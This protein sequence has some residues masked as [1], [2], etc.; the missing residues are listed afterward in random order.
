MSICTRLA[1]GRWIPIPMDRAMTSLRKLVLA[2]AA[3]VREAV[4][5][6]RCSMEVL[7][8]MAMQKM[9]MI[10]A[11]DFID[12]SHRRHHSLTTR[13]SNPSLWRDPIRV[14]GEQEMLRRSRLYEEGGGGGCMRKEEKAAGGRRSM[15]RSRSR[16]LQTVA[17]F[18]VLRI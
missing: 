7:M 18:C 6:D 12:V 3:D 16:R 14:L 17:F 1:S 4:G 8:A 11:I 15:W 10:G 9:L 13:G 5:A 2:G